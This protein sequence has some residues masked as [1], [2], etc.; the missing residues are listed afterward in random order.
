MEWMQL[1]SRGSTLSYLCNTLVLVQR[2]WQIKTAILALSM[3]FI[4]NYV[5]G[6]ENPCDPACVHAIEMLAAVNSDWWVA[7]TGYEDVWDGGASRRCKLVAYGQ[8]SNIVFHAK[9]SQHVDRDKKRRKPYLLCNGECPHQACQDKGGKETRGGI[10][11]STS[12]FWSGICCCAL[13]L[14]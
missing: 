5:V 10:A 8:K 14:D 6:I 12:H 11:E 9:Q 4:R 3:L 1:V 7:L 13:P 2:L